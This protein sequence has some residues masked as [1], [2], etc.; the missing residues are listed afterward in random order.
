MLI[1]NKSIRKNGSF[2]K[3]TRTLALESIRSIDYPSRVGKQDGDSKKPLKS[4]L[5]EC[6]VLAPLY[7]NKWW[8]VVT[9]RGHELH[10]D[11]GARQI[12]G[13][14][15]QIRTN[16]LSLGYQRKVVPIK[17]GEIGATHCLI[18]KQSPH[19]TILGPHIVLGHGAL[20]QI[21][22]V[23]C[24]QIA[25]VVSFYTKMAFFTVIETWQMAQSRMLISGPGR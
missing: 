17:Y 19:L 25:V 3:S 8:W 23:K 20:Y 13:P 7:G 11:S 10:L 18:P 5:N 21:C 1:L 16:R 12:R 6:L 2:P 22:V 4:L 15:H 14:F 9:Q 24:D